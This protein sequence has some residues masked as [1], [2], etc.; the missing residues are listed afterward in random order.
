[1]AMLIQEKVQSLRKDRIIENAPIKS[2]CLIWLNF[3]KKCFKFVS[4]KTLEIL[5]NTLNIFNVFHKISNVFMETNL[6]HFFLKFNHIRHLD[7]IGAFS[8]ILSFLKDCTFSWISMAMQIQGNRYLRQWHEGR[9]LLLFY[10]LL[11]QVIFLRLLYKYRKRH[12]LI[13][14]LTGAGSE[15]TL[16]PKPVYL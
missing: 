8:I 3:K 10:C 15:S 4:I 9:P 6:K 12:G 1:M 11:T 7:L 14:L 5:W 2:K 13:E 16:D